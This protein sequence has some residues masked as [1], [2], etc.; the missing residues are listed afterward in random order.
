M[1]SLL[2]HLYVNIFDEILDALN[3]I[4]QGDLASFMVFAFDIITEL[5][6]AT[7][8]LKAIWDASVLEKSS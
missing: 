3:A 1:D 8:G 7:K 4:T 5:H 6:L 2:F